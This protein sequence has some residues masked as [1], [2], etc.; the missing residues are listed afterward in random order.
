M[1]IFTVLGIITAIFFFVISLMA[2]LEAGIKRKAREKFFWN[3]E[4][5]EP[6]TDDE[7][8]DEIQSNER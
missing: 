5:V 6:L 4:K 8:I 2:I 3:M 7:L 1:I